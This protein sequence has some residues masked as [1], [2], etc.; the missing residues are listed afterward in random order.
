M[1]A[2]EVLKHVR[3]GTLFGCVECDI[4]VPDHLRDK[5]SEMSPIFK[6][7]EISR[8][9]IMKKFAEERNIM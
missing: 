7:M 1:T 2:D 5:F 8:E 6:N 4:H 9:D 3:D